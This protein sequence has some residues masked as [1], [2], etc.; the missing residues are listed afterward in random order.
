MEH[1]SPSSWGAGGD[2]P[3]TSTGGDFDPGTGPTGNGAGDCI[4]GNDQDQD[5]FTVAEGDCND[6]DHRVNPGAIEV[7]TDAMDPEAVPIDED[8]DGQTDEVSPSCDDGLEVASAAALDGARAMGLCL[9]ATESNKLP[10]VIEAKY[11]NADGSPL[12]LQHAA[13]V[14]IL[15]DFGPN[16]ATQEGSRMLALSTGKARL[17]TDP[18]ACGKY[19]CE[20][21]KLGSAPP[22]FPQDGSSGCQGGNEI[23]DDVGFELRVR[24]PTNATGF[25][26][27]F[28]FYS[29]E[30]PFYVCSQWN[31]QFV[32]LM[33]P[34][35][36][37]AMSGNISFDN[38]GNPVSV[39]LAHLDVCDPAGA[40]SYNGPNKPNPYCPKG[41]GELAGTG[42]DQWAAFFGAGATSWLETTAPINGGEV[43]T[44][45]L[46]VWDTGDMDYDA[47]VLV[48]G[49]Q[50]IAEPGS[51]VSVQTVPVPK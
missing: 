2:E 19:G 21:Y 10:G 17:P 33:Q 48:D 49:F 16:V 38:A 40:T 18:N 30:W 4:P 8:C 43:I 7:A 31:D 50:W 23:Y 29:F 14:G 9:Q 46:A 20:N 32:A 42:F 45:R 36:P 51:K 3:T 41:I 1:D 12:E 37:E 5:G 13:M 39:N 24:T 35:P 27:R 34:A 44:L 15:S 6:C 28:K 11:V 22:G 47:T 25:R 26:Y